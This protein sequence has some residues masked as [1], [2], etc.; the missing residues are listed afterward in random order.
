MD[1]LGTLEHNVRGLYELQ[2]PGRASWADWMYKNHVFVV[3]QYAERLADTH[4]GQVELVK[5][6]AMLHDIADTTMRRL[7]D[8]HEAVSLVRAR[9]LLAEAGFNKNETS[10][11]VDDAIRYHSCHNGQ[12]PKSLEGKILGN[13][14]HNYPKHLIISI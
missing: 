2:K 11:I 13:Y 9:D 4:N 5:A 6:A 12:V 14:I 1:R 7:D 8:N 3:T 10:L